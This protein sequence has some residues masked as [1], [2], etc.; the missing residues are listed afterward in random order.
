MADYQQKS[1]H[2]RQVIDD[3]ID[4]A[5]A[6]GAIDL[7]LSSKP[8]PNLLDNPYFGNPV[9][10]RGGYVVPPGETYHTFDLVAEGV[11]VISK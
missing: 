11:C 9:D 1:K 5:R 10:Q 3:A 6:V 2:T 8:N 7:D 4:R